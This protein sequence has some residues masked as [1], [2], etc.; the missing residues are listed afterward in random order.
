M[1]NLF[2]LLSENIIVF[3]EYICKWNGSREPTIF[4]AN[5]GLRNPWN[6]KFC[7]LKLCSKIVV[8]VYVSRLDQFN[9]F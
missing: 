4:Q 8:S 1:F 9:I 7:D 3:L 6:M 2:N 5:Q